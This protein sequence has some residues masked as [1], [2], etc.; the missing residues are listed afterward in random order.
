MDSDR[1]ARAV[2]DHRP[3]TNYTSSSR[4]SR[5]PSVSTTAS[6]GRT[7][8]TTI[9]STSG[10]AHVTVERNG[11]N[12][13]Y[14]SQRDREAIEYARHQMEGQRLEDEV[15]AYQ[16]D[17]RGP[18]PPEL[19]LDNIREHERRRS[20]S[21]F[22]GHTRRSSRSSS[23]RQ[24]GARVESGGAVIHVYPGSTV[25]MRPGKD[26][27]STLVI[28]SSTGKESSYYSGSR[29]SGNRRDSRTYG[30]SDGDSRREE[31]IREVE[32]YEQPTI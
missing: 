7:K 16:E 10:L 18:Q 2:V 5:R 27:G 22:S 29:S 31:T 24:E 9:S 8:A 19:T 3:R 6:S 28:G 1:T 12:I 14:L 32:D 13:T 15:R 25:E 26:G 20:Q 4:S 11:R 30:G 21:H 17:M 23:R